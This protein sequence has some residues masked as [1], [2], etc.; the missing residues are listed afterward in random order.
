MPDINPYQSLLQCSVDLDQLQEC[1]TRPLRL[2]DE[3]Y[4][5]DAALRAY[6]IISTIVV[7]GGSRVIQNFP[8]EDNRTS[9]SKKSPAINQKSSCQHTIWYQKAR[10][11]GKIVSE[12]G[13]A[14]AS[15]GSA[16]YNVI[17]TGGGPG[18][19]EAANRGASEAGAKSIGFNIILPNGQP[20]NKYTTPELTFWFRYFAIRKMH[21]AMRAKA[22]VIFPG[23]FGTLDELFEILT[24]KQV[25]R[26]S[27]LPIILFDRN[28]WKSVIN[29]QT[30]YEANMIDHHD[31]HM[32]EYVDTVEEAWNI[33][34]RYGLDICPPLIES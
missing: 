9:V 3:F 14:L 15:G 20:A 4:K 7:F 30:L 29:L 31:A 6:N 22:L 18:I 25:R 2:A 8:D 16:L 26:I 24:L 1:E 27:Q 28:Y 5:V 23:G 13:G 12:R 21:F 11:F 33:L 34:E 17:A 32:F 10:N 19:M